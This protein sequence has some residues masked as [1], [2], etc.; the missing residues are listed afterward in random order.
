MTIPSAVR[1][2]VKYLLLGTAWLFFAAGGLL[3]W[4]GGR[5]ISEFG[6]LDRIISEF[7]GI[8]AGLVLA[9]VGYVLKA[10]AENGD[11]PVGTIPTTGAKALVVTSRQPDGT[12]IRAICPLCD[13]AFST[14]AFDSDPNYP[15]ERKLRQWYSEHFN[16]V[17]AK[18]KELVPG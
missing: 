6:H 5:A 3:F 8:I 10:A 7:I 12:P 11:V 9:F 2:S 15:H 18:E 17:H 13:T 14:E 4:V 1:S 16:A